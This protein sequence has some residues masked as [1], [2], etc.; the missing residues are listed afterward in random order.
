MRRLKLNDPA[1]VAPGDGHCGPAVFHRMRFGILMAIALLGIGNLGAS[2]APAPGSTDSPDMANQLTAEGRYAEG[3]AAYDALTAGGRTSAALEYNRAQARWKLGQTG[4]AWAHAR[5][6][7]RMD[8]RDPSIRRALAQIATRVPSGSDRAASAGVLHRLTLNEW[9]VLALAAMWVWGL[10]LI[11]GLSRPVWRDRWRR[12]VWVAGTVAV[13]LSVLMLAA[14]WSRWREPDAILLRAD[15]PIR[16]S[17]LE[18]ARTAFLLPEASELRSRNRRG[19]WVMV[20]EPGSGRFGWVRRD[21]VYVLP[22]L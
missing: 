7:G 20:E 6:A 18:E 12:T 8:P 3:A 4:R 16:V 22:L 21:D 9:A 2:A 17:P 5:L 13:G 15:V 10:L 14:L 1:S 19:D 11:C